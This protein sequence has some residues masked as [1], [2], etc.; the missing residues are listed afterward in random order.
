MRVFETLYFTLFYCCF[1]EIAKTIGIFGS[2]RGVY[3]R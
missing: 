2:A 3:Q 1:L